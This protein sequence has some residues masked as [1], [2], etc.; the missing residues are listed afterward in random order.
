MRRAIKTREAQ[1]A[2]GQLVWAKYRD[3]QP[4]HFYLKEG[5]RGLPLKVLSGL[6]TNAT[7]CNLVPCVAVQDG[8]TSPSGLRASP[9][10]RLIRSL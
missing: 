1:K 8:Y 10:I 9:P 2:K 7:P 4:S 5:G 6:H 3:V